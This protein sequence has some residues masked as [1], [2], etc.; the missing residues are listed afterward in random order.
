MR[1]IIIV[2]LVFIACSCTK[3]Q[4]NKANDALENADAKEVLLIGTFHYNNPGA[5]VVKTQ[6]FDILKEESQ[7][8]LEVISATIEEYNPTKIFVEWPYDEQ[9][10]LDSLYQLHIQDQYFS[11]ERLSGFNLE[12]EVFQLAFR[13]AKATNLKKL[14]AIDYLETSFPFED[15]MNDIQVNNQTEIKSEIEEGIAKIT[16]DFDSKIE[17]GASLTELTYYLNTPEMREFSNY[18]HNELMLLTGGPKDFNGAFL[19]SEWY[20]RNLYMWSLI[21][22]HT[23]DSDERIM[24]LAG[25]SHAAMFEL[26]INENDNWKIKELEQIMT[27]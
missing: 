3:E 2:V 22:K 14:Y 9:E 12:N 17:S 4:S 21:Q 5:D 8:E 7:L 27:E 25:S 6:S 1:N 24:V 23:L 15:V 18:F 13:V 20:K 16:Q 19:T 26:F 11:D 10:E